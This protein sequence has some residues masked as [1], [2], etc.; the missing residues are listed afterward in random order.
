MDPD[1]LGWQA[2]PFTPVPAQPS[3]AAGTN[4][5]ELNQSTASFVRLKYVRTSG[6]GTINAKIALKSV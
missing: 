1:L 6:T 4:W 3:G 2:I 5:Y